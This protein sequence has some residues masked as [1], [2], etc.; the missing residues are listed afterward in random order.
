MK[1]YIALDVGGS[2]ILGAL[3]SEDGDKLATKKVKTFAAK[4]TQFVYDQIRLVIDTLLEQAEEVRGISVI[5]PGVVMN[6]DRVEYCPNVPLDQFPLGIRLREQYGLPVVL[7]N[8]VNLA[9]YGE[10]KT[11][12]QSYVNA[13]GIFVGTGVGGGLILDSR[14]YTGHGAAGEIGH[15]I[16]KPGGSICGCSNHG[17]LEAYASKSGMLSHIQAAQARGRQSTI[18]DYIKKDGSMISSDAFAECYAQGDEL[19]RELIQE[20]CYYLGIAVANLT[21]LLHPDVFIFGGGVMEAMGQSM[22]PEIE[23][24]AKIHALPAMASSIRCV[25]SHLGDD[26]GIVGGY[27]LIKETADHA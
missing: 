8:D 4:G 20:S 21:N 15:M 10:W 26:A 19:T 25:L 16:V 17:C 9:V 14:L 18:Y 11:L 12:E 22:L 6:H 13:V 7:G 5:L 23:R 27:Y 2:K 3:F 24:I 1:Q